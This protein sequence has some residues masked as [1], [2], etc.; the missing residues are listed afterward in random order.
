[1][2]S[3]SVESQL[4]SQAMSAAEKLLLDEIIAGVKWLLAKHS[5]AHPADAVAAKAHSDAISKAQ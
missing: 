2:P 5:A 3:V 4:E 1:M